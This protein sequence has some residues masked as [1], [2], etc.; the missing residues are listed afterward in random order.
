VRRNRGSILGRTCR[1]VLELQQHLQ[2]RLRSFQHS[3]KGGARYEGTFELLGREGPSA[4]L[5]SRTIRVICGISKRDFSTWEHKE[6]SIATEAGG[7]VV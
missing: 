3:R 4:S 7:E 6:K 1:V 2:L 5:P